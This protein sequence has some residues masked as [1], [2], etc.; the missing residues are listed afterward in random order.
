MKED[1]YKDIIIFEFML[2]IITCGFIYN[3]VYRQKDVPQ[4]YNQ[5]IVAEHKEQGYQ[6]Y[7]CPS[8]TIV[9]KFDENENNK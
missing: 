9:I 8:G 5:T 4:D 7:Q 3:E 2:L 1:I 6:I